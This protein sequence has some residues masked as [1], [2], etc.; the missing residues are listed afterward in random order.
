[1]KK[2]VSLIIIL[3]SVTLTSI[4]AHASSYADEWLAKQKAQD[5]KWMDELEADGNLTQEAIDSTKSKTNRK[6]NK[7]TTQTEEKTSQTQSSSLQTQGHGWVYSCD[8]LHII[9]LPED[10]ETGYTKS[11]NYGAIPQEH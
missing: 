9:G 11:G 10:A 1:M 4:T 2:I 3:I 6:P 8:E 7:K 5:E